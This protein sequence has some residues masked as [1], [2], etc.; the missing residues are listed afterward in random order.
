MA[1]AY[2][3]D[4]RKSVFNALSKG[5]RVKEIVAT[6]GIKKSAVY[7][8]KTREKETGSYEAFPRNPGR[9][10]GITD[11]QMG[12]LREKIIEEP[13]ITLEELKEQLQLPISISALCRIINNKLKL[14]H[15]KNSYRKRTKEGRC[16]I[17]T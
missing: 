3:K 8:W 2:S 9:K 15:K 12:K 1:I 11:E 4:L 17:K 14:R 7:S 16:S 10:P 13:D 6:F 5:M